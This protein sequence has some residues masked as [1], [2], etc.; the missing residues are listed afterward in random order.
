MIPPNTAS[1][2]SGFAIDASTTIQSG[3]FIFLNKNA[4]AYSD[5]SPVFVP[6][7]KK[8]QRNRPTMSRSL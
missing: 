1:V 3:T 7:A 5:A 8:S 2:I 6:S 4:L